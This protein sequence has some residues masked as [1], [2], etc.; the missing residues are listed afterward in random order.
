MSTLNTLAL[1]QNGIPRSSSATV[2][3]DD[4]RRAR[5][6]ALRKVPGV[7][8]WTSDS[9]SSGFS[10]FIVRNEDEASVLFEVLQK[11]SSSANLSARL[12]HLTQLE[13]LKPIDQ[14]EK[15]PQ[16]DT[17]APS[18]AS[19]KAVISYV[20]DPYNNDA[21]TATALLASL[22]YQLICMRRHSFAHASELAYY[23]NER[24][25]ERIWPFDKLLVLFR[26]LLSCPYEGN[27]ACIL[28][29]MPG[30]VLPQGLVSTLAILASG[31]GSAFKLA[32]ISSRADVEFPSVPST[33]VAPTKPASFTSLAPSGRILARAPTWATD[34]SHVFR[35][36]YRSVDMPAIVDRE[37]ASLLSRRPAMKSVQ[38]KLRQIILDGHEAE[39]SKNNDDY[40]SERGKPLFSGS[41]AEVVASVRAWLELITNRAVP[42]S[43]ASIARE[44]PKMP[45]SMAGLYAAT[46]SCTPPALLLTIQQLL[47]WLSLSKR[48]MTNAELAVALAVTHAPGRD[49][50][51]GVD[52]LVNAKTMDELD[53]HKPVNV[54]DDLLALL[55]SAVHTDD[56]GRPLLQAELIDLLRLDRA[57][58]AG[59]LDADEE[60]IAKYSLPDAHNTLGRI[61][62]AFLRI[63][64]DEYPRITESIVKNQ[65]FFEYA[66]LHWPYHYAAG[67]PSRHNTPRSHGDTTSVQSCFTY[68]DDA[69]LMEF[70]AGI[71]HKLRKPGL[72]PPRDNIALCM[73]AD[74]GCLDLISRVLRY[75][76]GD[77]AAGPTSSDA[78]VSGTA[79]S[80]SGLSRA[81]LYAVA[82]GDLD[83]VKL[84]ESAG[85]KSRYAV[86]VA[87]A[88]NQNALLHHFGPLSDV[89]DVKDWRE[90]TPIQIAAATGNVSALEDLLPSYT[91]PGVVDIVYDTDTDNYET[92][93]WDYDNSY[94]IPME[95]PILHIAC[96]FG[97]VAV[98]KRLLQ[99][100]SIDP[101]EFDKYQN[102]PIFYA[103]LL[104]QPDAMRALLEDSRVD[105]SLLSDVYH[106]RSP[107]QVAAVLQRV[108]MVELLLENLQS[109]P[110]PEVV[111]EDNASVASDP[112]L[113][114]QSPLEVALQITDRYSLTAL[115]I[116]AYYGQVNA[117]KALVAHGSSGPSLLQTAGHQMA[118]PLH[119]AA[120]HDHAAFMK[121]LL[122]SGDASDQLEAVLRD[123]NGQTALHI[124]ARNSN[125]AASM[126]VL[127]A[128]HVKE[129]I[130]L[131]AFDSGPRSA[132]HHA[133]LRGSAANARLLLDAG[134]TPDAVDGDSATPLRIACRNGF[135]DVVRILLDRHA[136][137]SL[138]DSSGISPLLAAAWSGSVPI[139]KELLERT[140]SKAL[141]D[142][143]SGGKSALHYAIMSK[144]YEAVVFVIQSINQTARTP[145]TVHSTVERPGALG[146]QIISDR[147][148]L[149]IDQSGKSMP[150]EAAAESDLLLKLLP[151][152]QA[153]VPD[154][155]ALCQTMLLRAASVGHLR[156]VEA[157]VKDYHVDLNVVDKDGRTALSFAAESGRVRLVRFLAR[158][159]KPGRDKTG[160]SPLS[161]AISGSH[162]RVVDVLLSHGHKEEVNMTN[163]A[164]E[165]PLYLAANRNNEAIVRLLLKHNAD[166]NTPE[167]HNKNTPLHCAVMSATIAIVRLIATAPGVDGYARNID[168]RTPMGVAAY[169]KFLGEARALLE[170]GWKSDDRMLSRHSSPLHDAYNN[171]DMIRLF[172]DEG[173]QDVNALDS[174]GRTALHLA[175]R[176]LYGQVSLLLDLGANP[177]I[178]DDENHETS[179]HAVAYFRDLA[180]F[181][182]MLAHKL[183]PSLSQLKY[184]ISKTGDNIFDMAVNSDNTAVVTYLL[185]AEDSPFRVVEQSSNGAKA[186]KVAIRN[187]FQDTTRVLLER[188]KDSVSQLTDDM[189][190]KHLGVLLEAVFQNVSYTLTEMERVAKELILDFSEA[191]GDSGMAGREAWTYMLVFQAI[192]GYDQY[193]M[194]VRRPFPQLTTGIWAELRDHNGWTYPQLLDTMEEIDDTPKSGSDSD[195]DSMAS[196]PEELPSPEERLLYGLEEVVV[197][198]DDR[199]AVDDMPD[200]PQ[201]PASWS[202][203]L[204]HTA[205]TWAAPISAEAED[206][207][208]EAGK[209]AVKEAG[210]VANGSGAAPSLFASSPAT[211]SYSRCLAMADYP[212][213]PNSRF[214]YS[215]RVVDKGDGNII[216]V[217]VGY[218]LSPS[219]RMPGWEPGTWGFHGDDGGYFHA[220][221]YGVRHDE[222]S[223][224]GTG[225]TVDVYID[226]AQHKLFFAVNGRVLGK[227]FQATQFIRENITNG[228]RPWIRAGVWPGVSY[229]GHWRRCLNR[230]YVWRPRWQRSIQGCRRQ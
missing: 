110:A 46:L 77:G 174:Q 179:L 5:M 223:L 10:G 176:S 55:G 210:G 190:R 170:A 93:I 166:P 95:L 50:G 137:V 188:V 143:D 198:D 160:Q 76:S 3:S 219:D 158:K 173:K 164:N 51:G 134:A 141:L 64:Q 12:R 187:N 157:L 194:H 35:L 230:G 24:S 57:D 214:R 222:S 54:Q 103:G 4:P 107:L 159:T 189:K 185:D 105:P 88:S 52:S 208:K 14:G 117:G 17:A 37:L 111:A 106:R 221:G 182:E 94:Y 71:Y 135:F 33:P 126:R 204:S 29:E 40:G 60:S 75:A 8:T 19:T 163:E 180:T 203:A 79:V 138:S 21:N 83:A 162:T 167:S 99:E 98:V 122:D 16:Q 144:S 59:R 193:K 28:W 207:R 23:L 109:R 7:S 47:A 65:P 66:V 89:A 229:R 73:A 136:D 217:G 131:D 177:M 192:M 18:R 168:D 58:P 70:W 32:V 130:T 216:G 42:I 225:D 196:V 118:I 127:V 212:I 26:S 11:D 112:P 45:A 100:T 206:T 215:I 114:I 15:T 171:E 142:T 191:R 181:E 104:Q 123:G 102:R 156:N 154:L 38:D 149:L 184:M 152:V 62:L 147:A 84:L 224:F 61:C 129:H 172:V 202:A 25:K 81:L 63:C 115:H 200:T 87:V 178:V 78:A 153:R 85:A 186:L 165:S 197:T 92:T 145:R 97:H 213:P 80:R 43:I 211:R 34:E 22:C 205:I 82:Q 146:D 113:S 69:G 91:S 20:F 86:H 140:T 121:L 132:L 72:N 67:S 120:A 201:L 124:V 2:I 90:Y 155:D 218:G 227:F 30:T 128:A 148:D 53:A 169:F 150:I 27:V 36:P 199:A 1:T 13:Q 226:T 175:S 31:S 49:C 41:H 56:S 228:C 116:A 125:F 151:A 68:F 6:A 101:N 183:V 48:P 195:I 44:A 161:Y 9:I 96:V 119:F 139:M 209:E 39:D 220:S 74:V 133:A 108:D